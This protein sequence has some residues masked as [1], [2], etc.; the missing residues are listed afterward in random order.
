MA[1][2]DDQKVA[3]RLLD[4]SLCPKACSYCGQYPADMPSGMCPTCDGDAELVERGTT[5]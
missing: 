3:D 1:R 4:E 2:D 5:P